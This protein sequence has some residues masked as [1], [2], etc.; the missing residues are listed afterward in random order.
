M[1]GGEGGGAGLR[2]GQSGNGVTAAEPTPPRRRGGGRRG[3]GRAPPWRKRGS[4]RAPG[5]RRRRSPAAAPR[6][7]SRDALGEERRMLARRPTAGEAPPA[8][9]EAGR[10]RG[11]SRR[12][13]SGGT[14]RRRPEE[15]AAKAAAPAVE[16]RRDS[17]GRGADCSLRAARQQRVG[18][19]EEAVGR[20]ADVEGRR[21]PRKARKGAG[22]STGRRDRTAPGHRGRR[23]ALREALE[24]RQPRSG[25]GGHHHRAGRGARGRRYGASPSNRGGPIYSGHPVEPKKNRRRRGGAGRF[26]CLFVLED[27]QQLVQVRTS[28]V[29]VVLRAAPA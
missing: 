25:G 27:E 18:A 16:R 24:R 11:G 3:R 4:P 17:W 23:L 13:T 21:A 19:A 6:R 12:P 7:G 15:N 2:A 9:R 28:A 1:R 5:R 8:A 20:A 14:A 22:A 26:V 29:V 10:A